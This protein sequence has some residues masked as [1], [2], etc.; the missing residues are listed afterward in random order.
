MNTNVAGE[1]DAVNLG[2]VEVAGTAL[3]TEQTSSVVHSVAPSGRPFANVK[4]LMARPSLVAQGQLPMSIG[5]FHFFDITLDTLRTHL[6]W[7]DDVYGLR[8][9]LRFHIS[10]VATPVHAGLFGVAFNPRS[11]I[12]AATV[13]R[14]HVVQLMQLPGVVMNIAKDHSAEITIPWHLPI[15]YMRTSG[16]APTKLGLARTDGVFGT[17]VLYTLSELI[18][19]PNSSL[20]TYRIML[21]LENVELFGTTIQTTSTV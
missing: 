6:R 15:E 16:A 4:E 14:T 10:V 2:G 21:S 3:V 7:V 5:I 12:T 18:K 19:G 8:A 13:E 1:L 11:N 17:L 20:P 9:T